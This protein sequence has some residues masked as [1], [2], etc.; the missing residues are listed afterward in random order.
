[1]FTTL[2]FF[3]VANFLMLGIVADGFWRWFR[4]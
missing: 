3:L 1:M 2:A 4:R